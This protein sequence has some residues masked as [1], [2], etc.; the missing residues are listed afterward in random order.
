[1][2]T[3]VYRMSNGTEVTTQCYH[4]FKPPASFEI[5]IST[6]AELCVAPLMSGVVNNVST[7]IA[8]CPF[9]IFDSGEISDVQTAF[10]IPGII[11][12]VLC[13]LVMLDSLWVMF[14]YTG[15]FQMRRLRK[16]IF[17]S[18]T[19]ASSSAAGGE[20]KVTSGGAASSGYRRRPVQAMT[21]Y[22]L[23]GAVLSIVWFCMGPL[24]ALV[25]RNNVVCGSS[26]GFPLEDITAG[27]AD[28]TD[29]SCA[30]QRYSYAF[31]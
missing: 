21:L 3:A 1:V 23:A 11:G 4:P 7:C 15:G 14:E 22:Q 25:K 2:D 6:S 9:P 12:V 18:S 13:A 20:D 17:W 8:P 19:A 27:T 16:F 5:V 26:A 10:I 31:I 24:P 29:I 30:A 28:T